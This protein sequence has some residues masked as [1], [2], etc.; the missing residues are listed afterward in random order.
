MVIPIQYDLAYDFSEGVAY[1]DVKGKKGTKTIF[2]NSCLPKEIKNRF[3]EAASFGKKDI[4][5]EEL[6]KVIILLFSYAFH[7]FFI[8]YFL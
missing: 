3:P 4:G 2:G 8:G 7:Y 1:V 5:S 6:R